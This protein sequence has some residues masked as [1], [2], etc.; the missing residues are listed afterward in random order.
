LLQKRTF[1]GKWY[2]FFNEPPVL[3]VTQAASLSL[4]VI[5]GQKRTL[6]ASRAAPIEYAMR[7][8]KVRKRRAHAILRL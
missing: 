2:K 4:L 6:A 3:P 5:L 7:P 1:A 8:I